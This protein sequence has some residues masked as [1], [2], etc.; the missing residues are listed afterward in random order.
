VTDQEARGGEQRYQSAFPDN[1]EGQLGESVTNENDRHT[2]VD[3]PV[4]D[5]LDNA[6]ENSQVR[7]DDER[8]DDS[9]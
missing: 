7:T 3:E 2:V 8:D 4:R 9:R 6:V 1:G 5:G